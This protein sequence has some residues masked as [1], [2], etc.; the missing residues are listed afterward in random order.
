[1]KIPDHPICRSHACCDAVT[2]LLSLFCAA[3]LSSS[4]L[5]SIGC[6]LG[7]YNKRLN[8]DPVKPAAADADFEGDNAETDETS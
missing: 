3:I 6:D 4:C 5:L 7:T 1:M 2:N 8:D